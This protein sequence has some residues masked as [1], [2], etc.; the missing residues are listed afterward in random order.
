LNQRLTN[1]GREPIA[2]G[3]GLHTG[4]AVVGSIGSPER[5]EFTAI[6]SAVNIASRLESLT[7]SVHRVLLLSAATKDHLCKK[8]ALEE[9]PPQAV[10]GLEQPMAVFSIA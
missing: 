6:G 3:I 5:L 7:K 4:P 8:T 1:E 2:I 9:L 10:R